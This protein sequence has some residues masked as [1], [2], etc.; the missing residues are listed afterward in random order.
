[1]SDAHQLSP[2]DQLNEARWISGLTPID[3]DIH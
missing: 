1:M 3:F 2:E